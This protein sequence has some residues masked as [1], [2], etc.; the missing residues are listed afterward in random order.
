MGVG[1]CPV[2]RLAVLGVPK[3]MK[4]GRGVDAKACSRQLVS[5]ACRPWREQVEWA[6]SALVL[7]ARSHEFFGDCYT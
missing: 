7:S 5:P 6:V 3:S 1:A 2:A 4:A